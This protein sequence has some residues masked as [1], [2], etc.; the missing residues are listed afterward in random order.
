MMRFPQRNPKI[1]VTIPHLHHLPQSPIKTKELSWISIHPHP[2]I[3]KNQTLRLQLQMLAKFR[4]KRRLRTTT[5]SWQRPHFRNLWKKW[6]GNLTHK[7]ESF[8]DFKIFLKPFLIFWVEFL[9]FASNTILKMTLVFQND[10]NVHI[11]SCGIKS[12][13]FS[14]MEEGMKSIFL[15]K[16]TNYSTVHKSNPFSFG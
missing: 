15:N 16:N 6:R 11:D 9:E 10:E 5:G 12:V 4:P 13:T 14:K 8:T 3:T 7:W 1:A 2:R